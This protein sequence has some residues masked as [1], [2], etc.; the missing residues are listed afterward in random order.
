MDRGNQFHLG[1]D[2]QGPPRARRPS[3]A[4]ARG[5]V[6]AAPRL[7]ATV[8]ALAVA[9]VLAWAAL[10]YAFSS[11]VL[12]MRAA[13]GIAETEAMS[14]FTLGLVL[15]GLGSTVVGAAI[16]RGHARAVMGGGA[17]LAAAGFVL[18]ARV[19]GAAGLHLAWALLGLSMAML[20]YE[21]AFAALT[22]RFPRDYLRGITA[23]TLVGGFASTLA[24]PATAA[25]IDAF[26]WRAALLVIAAVLAGIVAPLNAWALR[27]PAEAPLVPAA[28]QEG[29]PP[30]GTTLRQALRLP[31]FWLLTTTFTLHAFAT[32]ALWAHMVPALAAKGRV[33]GA[34]IAIVVWIGPAQVAGRLL[35]VAFGRHASVQSLGLV[36]FAALPVAYVLYAFGEGASALYGFALLFGVS[37]GL[38]TIVRGGLLPQVFGR[39]EIGRIGGTVNGVALLSRAAAPLATAAALAVVGGYPRLMLGL[40]AGS[41]LALGCFVAA[42]G[43]IAAQ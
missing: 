26:G 30:T 18:W 14:A 1:N 19:Q 31:A 15:W 38:V 12:P 41:T 43:R 7:R 2:P 25:L 40:A 4:P 13:L 36:V 24:Y 16:D 10:Y 37:N 42:R 35:F 3:R 23:L 33:G 29:R 22:R 17:L 39:L 21:P 20:L 28:A 5:A 8:A 27:G 34:A 32:A 11:F 6:S 9:Q